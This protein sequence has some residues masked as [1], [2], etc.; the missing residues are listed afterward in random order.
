MFGRK[1]LLKAIWYVWWIFVWSMYNKKDPEDLKKELCEAKEN[2][3]CDGR[4]LLNSFIET[5]K[6]LLKDIEKELLSDKNKE[7]FNRKKEDILKIAL[8]YRDEWYKLLDEIK[9]K[10]KDFISE[11][12]NKL[13]KLY[14]EKKEEKESY[15]EIS[16]KKIWELKENLKSVFVE[17]SNEIK[18][19]IKK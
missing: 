10:W 17:M 8:E 15:K 9:L 1:F 5:H 18:K 13:E 3:K 14:N 11:A 16:P 4:V 19:K 12:S 7:L 2:W 6:N